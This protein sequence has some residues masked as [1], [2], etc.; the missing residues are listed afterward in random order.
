MIKIARK[1]QNYNS[2]ETGLTLILTL[3]L[4]LPPYTTFFLTHAHNNKIV[5]T[6]SSSLSLLNI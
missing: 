3:Q 6:S 4:T 5:G 2:M 1:I